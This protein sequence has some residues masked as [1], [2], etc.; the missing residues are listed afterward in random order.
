[1][2][3]SDQATRER[4]DRGAGSEE[5]LYRSERSRVVRVRL[6]GGQVIVVKEPRGS[7]SLARV[8][9]EL[10]I[11]ERLAGIAGI[12]VLA[13]GFTR[14]GT[15]TLE[16]TGAQ[17]LT[18]VAMDTRPEPARLVELAL[19]VG[20]ILAAVHRRGVVHKDI[21]PNNVLVSGP[22]W[23]PT[24]IDYDIASTFAEDRPSFTHA[25]QIAGTL[26]YIAP[27]QTGRT[28]RGVDQ[29]ADLY[30]L[31][32]TLYAVATGRA[33]FGEDDP[34]HL[35]HAHV[36]Q[37]PQPPRE[38]NP[39]LPDMLAAI[40]LRL[41]EKEPDRRYQSADGLVYDLARLAA[42]EVT[43]FELGQRDFP[44]RLAAPS[45]L[46]GRDTE[47]AVLHGAFEEVRH[48][49]RRAVLVRGAPGVGKTALIDELKPAVTKAHGWFVTGK[50]DQYRSDADSDGVRQA[51]RTLGRMLLAEPEAR[52]AA[53]RTR[54]LEAVGP[55]AGLVAGVLP[56]FEVLLGV[57]PTA[58]VAGDPLEAE[59][60]I[61]QA[62][63]DML[64]AVASPEHPVVM[65]LDDLQWA[66]AT[67]IALVDAVVMDDSLSAVLL[68]GAYRDSEV[69]ATHPL[70][71]KLNRWRHSAAPPEEITLDNLPPAGLGA[72]LAEMLRLGYEEAV[73][74]AEAVGTRTAGNP[75]DTV[76]LVNGLRR[77]GV[78]VVGDRGWTWDAAT[79][80]GYVGQ[81]D[82]VD[83]LAARI[84]RLAE[85]AQAVVRVL[86]CLG[87]EV[88]LD[89]L[90]SATGL[91]AAD[92]AERLTPSLEDGLLV[93]QRGGPDT[94]RFR[95]DRVQQA[96][97]GGLA[98]DERTALHLD[99]ARRLAEHP[100]LQPVAAEQYLSAVGEI[101]EATERRRAADLFRATAAGLRLINPAMAERLLTAAIDLLDPVEPADSPLLVG[102]E[103][104]R[105]AMLYALGRPDDVDQAFARIRD[106]NASP[107]QVAAAAC[108]QITSL[109][110]RVRSPEALA[111]GLDLLRQ[112]G[113]DVP[114]GEHVF[115][116][117]ERGMGALHQ[118]IDEDTADA[119]LARPEVTDPTAVAIA[120][121]INYVM[122]AAYYTGDPIMA[123]LVVEARR[124]WSEYGPC[125]PLVGPIAHAGFV[126]IVLS[127][128]YHTGYRVVRRMLATGEAR[129][130]EPQTSQAR[131]L[132]SLGSGQW[133]DPLASNI[134]DARRAHE[135][136]ARHGDLLNAVCT[137]YASMPQLLDSADTIDSYLAD[138][139]AGLAY[140]VRSSSDQAAAAFVA[141]RQLG[142]ALRGET[143]A[144]GSFTDETFDEAAHFAAVADNPTAAANVHATRAIAA[145]VYGDAAALATHAAATVPLRPFIPGTYTMLTS[146]LIQALALAHRIRQADVPPGEEVLA[147]F[148]ENRDWLSRRADDAPAN[149]THLRHLVDAELA[150]ATG[151][152]WTA[153]TRFE[154]AMQAARTGRHG[155]QTPYVIERAALFHL[156]SD[157]GHTA[158]P[159]LAEARRAYA[160]WGIAG[161]VRRME[162]EHP[163][164]RIA[165]GTQRRSTTRTSTISVTAQSID[166]LG[167]L[168]ASQALS[169]ETNLDRLLLRVQETLSALAG[170]TAV[171]TLLWDD[172]AKA[173]LLPGGDG[174]DRRELTL[175]QAA[176]RRLVPLSPIRYAERIREPL[177]VDDLITDDRFA[178]DEYTAGLDRCSLLIVPVLA[179]GTAR[180][181][182]VLENRLSHGAFSAER[183]DA[184][185][186]I[187][188]Q[189]AVSLDNALVYR[190]LERK[191]AQRTEALAEA[192]A[193]LEQLS[194]TDALTG[195]A[196]RRY[197]EEALGA[198]WEEAVRTGAPIG[199]AMIDIDHF[200]LYN[201]NYGHLGGD[202]CLRRVAAVLADN[203]RSMD[204]VARYGGEEFAV[205]LPDA[206]PEVAGKVAQ[207]FVEAVRAMGEPHERSPMGKVTVSVGVAAT[208]PEAGDELKTLV[209][210][211]DE[212]LYVAK[213][214]G[215]D[216]I[217]IERA[218]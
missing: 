168:T 117:I 167:I 59:A 46:V 151:D 26:A 86:A 189:L 99:L 11:I 52:L 154:A 16:D 160:A 39:E 132:F 157:L 51:L 104:E 162:L 15:I 191:V 97:H 19:G 144:A 133:F 25:S 202:R 150:W 176:E 161:K 197:L 69:S 100:K 79:I 188:G 127:G 72:L 37:P 183:L 61:V 153:V 146:H 121:L 211:A 54:I 119:D 24:L 50:F 110:S 30:S 136:L 42:G 4:A 20:R 198:R 47:T 182:L 166:M 89:L 116:E 156:A 105:H 95:H 64:R 114:Q 175:D 145:A 34:L 38:L 203:V 142:R 210:R 41:L 137:G 81:G 57:E 49:E 170:A 21:N 63:L 112:L 107:V 10:S 215:R 125:A 73:G 22:S 214:R 173:W 85:P 185:N 23:E 206:T 62:G 205:I 76:E 190:S 55:N 108:V 56:E 120:R 115:V 163:F 165:G 143:R 218:G 80:R 87:G 128:D 36:A 124:L 139:E 148:A 184:V 78:L 135:G 193:R 94:V 5:E 204:M 169:S 35:I 2:S 32:A 103:I 71:A 1:M 171:R 90:A 66:P 68:V 213:R 31:G 216:Q 152:K 44:L 82:V 212:A 192:N 126:A 140:A 174:T 84:A 180:A 48:G 13:A 101:S 181:I 209:E 147:E 7:T 138:V 164:L 196:N 186:L 91:S 106:R 65:V 53:Y 217:S 12:P 98:A 75:F 28:G 27:E 77:E 131:F 88:E 96:A 60:R 201:D 129:G 134:N 187:A 111:L 17:P 177:V 172:E 118:W 58:T 70:T 149:F 155:W 102:L 74:L 40:I 45:R 93:L 92:L 33:P 8:R 208:R 9:H 194:I 158:R 195:L 6:A 67:P 123:W 141:Y 207:R 83:L 109:S 200:K 178:R 3:A 199:I 14:P 43:R 122:P 29:R 159:L 113:L 179:R 130:Y 18:D